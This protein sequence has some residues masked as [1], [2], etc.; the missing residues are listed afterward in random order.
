MPVNT[1]VE[2]MQ[3]VKKNLPTEEDKRV[4]KSGQIKIADL[5]ERMESFV[6]ILDVRIVPKSEFIKLVNKEKQIVVPLNIDA[7]KFLIRLKKLL[8]DQTVFLYLD[9]YALKGCEF[10]TWLPFLER[11]QKSST[12]IL[13]NINITAVRRLASRNSIEKGEMNDKII[14]FHKRLDEVFGGNYWKESLLNLSLDQRDAE[15]EL[16][17]TFKKKILKYVKYVGYCPVKV[18]PNNL[19]K[20]YIMYLSNSEDGLLLMNDI[21][22]KAYNTRMMKSIS[23]VLPLFPDLK[24]KWNE[25]SNLMELKHIILILIKSNLKKSRKDYWKIICKDFF[26][27][28]IEREYRTAVKELHQ[29]KLILFEDIRGTKRLN[30]SSLLYLPDH[31]SI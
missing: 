15:E 24:I 18:K 25:E 14:G 31:K 8:T 26:M 1:M 11:E 20:F 4:M 6:P 29:D 23:K 10:N 9:P 12:E 7:N 27:Q 30:D 2:F 17:R 21:M 16:M 28:Y 19:A 3:F 22:C 5:L 13:V